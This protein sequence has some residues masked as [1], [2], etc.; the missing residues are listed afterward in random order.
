MDLTASEHFEYVI[1]RA[2]EAELRRT[3]ESTEG[4]SRAVLLAR[5]NW[6]RYVGRQQLE[7]VRQLYPSYRLSGYSIAEHLTSEL[8]S[9]TPEFVRNQTAFRIHAGASRR[10]QRTM[11]IAIV[12]AVGF[13]FGTLAEAAPRIRRASIILGAI[14]TV[15]GAIAIPLIHWNVF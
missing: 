8:H 4:R 5:A 1:A 12:A 10:A 15:L 6:Q 14:T 9:S 13:G 11:A 2:L 7:H 3:A